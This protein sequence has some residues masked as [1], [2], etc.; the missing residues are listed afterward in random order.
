MARWG[1]VL[2]GLLLSLTVIAAQDPIGWEERGE[3]PSET[4]QGNGYQAVY[5][6]TNQ[7][8]FLMPTALTIQLN[9]SAGFSKDDHCSGRRLQSKESCEVTVHYTP[10]VSGAGYYQLVMRYAQNVVPLPKK[11]TNAQGAAPV[12]PTVALGIALPN[13]LGTE[14]SYPVSF[15][16]SNTTGTPLT[17]LNFSYQVQPGDASF[18]ASGTDCPTTLAVNQ[19]CQYNGIYVTGDQTG[20]ANVTLQTTYD[21]NSNGFSSGSNGTIFS[22]SLQI[23]PSVAL[24]NQISTNQS[25]SVAF[26]LTNT[27][28]FALSTLIIAPDASP[29][30]ASLIENTPTD[31]SNLLSNQSCTYTGTYTSGNT[32]GSGSANVEVSFDQSP[33]LVTG[34]SATQVSQPNLQIQV[35]TLLP[36]NV[37]TNSTTAVGFKVTNQ[38]AFTLTGLTFNLNATPVDADFELD[39][40]TSTCGTTLVA[41]QSC[42]ISG[43]YL[44]NQ[45]A[46]AGKAELQV[47]FD[48]SPTVKT[49]N[50]GTTI[51]TKDL[52]LIV[53]APNLP[54]AFNVNGMTALS[55]Q[56]TNNSTVA[57]TGIQFVDQGSTNGSFAVTNNGCT[58]TL[59]QGSSCVYAGTY[60]A[61]NTAGPS[62]IAM[63]AQSA[64]GNSNTAIAQTTLSVPNVQVNVISG[65]GLPNKVST[66]M[67]YPVSFSVTNSSMFTLTGLNVI[68]SALPNDAHLTISTNGCSSGTL[69]VNQ[70]CQVSGTYQTNLNTGS[71]Q[72][73]ITITSTQSSTG[74]SGNSPTTVSNPSLLITPLVAL[75]SNFT[76]NSNYYVIYT[77]TNQSAFDL[78]NL[79]L[80]PTIQPADATVTEGESSD[81][82]VTLAAGASCAYVGAYT[83]GSTLGT[84]TIRLHAGYDQSPSGT[85]SSLMSTTIA[86]STVGFTTPTNLPN[87][88]STNSSNDVIFQLS[89]SS[90]FPITGIHFTTLSV[91]GGIF[92]VNPVVTTC[93]MTLAS[94]SN[95]L[96]A[97]TYTAGGVEA[98]GSLMVQVQYDQGGPSSQSVATTITAPN[99]FISPTAPPLPTQISTNSTHEMTFTLTNHSAFDLT[100]F[101]ITIPPQTPSDAILTQTSNNCGSTLAVNA[102]CTFTGNYQTKNT[103][104]SSAAASIKV[105]YDQNTSGQIGSSATTI[106]A[107]RVDW[108]IDKKL[109]PTITANSSAQ[110]EF[111]LQNSS[112]F[113]IT[114]LS[115]SEKTNNGSATLAS[116]NCGSE[117]PSNS[118]CSYAGTFTAGSSAGQASV[119]VTAT[120]DQGTAV[121]NPPAQTIV[122]TGPGIYAATTSQGLYQSLDNGNSFTQIAKSSI[123]ATTV[124]NDFLTMNNT[125][126]VATGNNLYKSTDGTNFSSVVIDS[127]ANVSPENLVF[128]NGV[129]YVMGFSSSTNGY[130]LY[131]ST[132][133]GQTF[134]KKGNFTGQA[135]YDLAVVPSTGDIFV[136]TSV[137]LYKSTDGGNSFSINA[138]VGN[139]VVYRV[140]VIGN[141]IYAGTADGLYRS[142]DGQTFSI[143]SLTEVVF[144]LRAVGNTLYIGTANRNVYQSSNGSTFTQIGSELSDCQPDDLLV[145][146]NVVYLACGDGVYESVNG[147]NF[148][149]TAAATI[150]TDIKRLWAYP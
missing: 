116:S 14:Q 102:A 26:T 94:G 44:T 54:N 90:A 52:A 101:V 105:T 5:R 111:V 38:S 34:L 109:P 57:L 132:N 18:V 29:E 129:F 30:D 115:L 25:Y 79:V 95:C 35:S 8:P 56:L 15:T 66:Q 81:C 13:Q 69:A 120:Y 121:S 24:P 138:S 27:S 53:A 147:A 122:S 89:N 91:N 46:G 99:L 32:L 107:P 86:A 92:E 150:S 61:G 145:L 58:G 40:S 6:F 50:N 62:K 49:D 76:P 60:T 141:I 96:Y 3:I 84:S 20:L 1:I 33:N 143:T 48:Q 149:Q 133:N 71:G 77:L 43:W 131:T 112:A 4:M 11:I 124:V 80:S 144:A 74:A 93:G 146:G 140:A 87:K 75:P 2:G 136:T 100:N 134:T 123:G 148:S 125:L 98:T 128:S 110:L 31:C 23:T 28:P 73:Q 22:P 104:S 55:F 39:P 113:P 65:S 67:S 118:Q 36:T 12:M 10:Q 114:T 119:T 108:V 59:T 63:Q 126:F 17:N 135:P 103:I 137:G 64:Q 72:A 37:D 85:D 70:T 45:Q 83:S 127:N 51:L 47:S 88:I 139:R 41:S 78:T 42:V 7:L 130:V 97:G 16:I 106:S 82:D 68:P 142:T 117:L 19:S 21:Q 9:G